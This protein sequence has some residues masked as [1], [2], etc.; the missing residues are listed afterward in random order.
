MFKISLKELIKFAVILTIID[1]IWIRL[2]ML[3]K[4]KNWFKT[5]NN[6]MIY[7]YIAIF[8]AY[9]IMVLVYPLF[10]KD[11]NKNK[12]LIKAALIGATVFGLY[13]FTLAGIF[14]TYGLDFALIETIWG[15]TLYTISTFIFQRLMK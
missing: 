6:K 8:L 9:S 5:L 11:S 10:I 15:A 14:G 12:E 7:N 13:G 4:Y 2:Y 1:T 3:P